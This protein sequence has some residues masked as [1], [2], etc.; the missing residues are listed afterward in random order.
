MFRAMSGPWKKVEKSVV[1]Y[2]ESVL[3]QPFYQVFMNMSFVGPARDARTN[4][5][6]L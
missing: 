5:Y 4:S 6:S 1:N 2:Y 3:V